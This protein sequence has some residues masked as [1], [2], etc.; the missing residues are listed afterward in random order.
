[1]QYAIAPA[2]DGPQDHIKEAIEKLERRRDICVERLN[3]I[4]GISCVAPKGAFYAFPKLEI[5][6]D[7]KKWV[8]GLIEETGVVTVH[9]SGFGVPGHFRIVLLPDEDTLEKACNAIADYMKKY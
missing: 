1:M 5:D 7:D 6:V 4:D 3:A 8:E 2:L 9:G